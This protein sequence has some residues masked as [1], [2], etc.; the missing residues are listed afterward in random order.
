MF[1]EGF[2]LPEMK[3]AALHDIRKSLAVTL[4]LAGRFTRTGQ[5]LGDA[6]FIANIADIKVDDKIQKLY[7]ET[8]DWNDLLKDASEQTIQEKIDLQELVSGF[9]NSLT[10]ITIKNLTPAMSTVIYKTTCENWKPENYKKGIH[11]SDSF[12]RIEH[13][14]NFQE[15]TLVLVTGKKILVDWAQSKDIFNWDWGLYILF[16]D[17]TQNLLFIHSS[18]KVIY[19]EKLAKAVAGEVELVKGGPVFR[20]FAGINLLKLQN[21]GLIEHLGRLIR[22]TMRAG[23]DVELGLTQAQKQKSSKSNIFG[24]GYESGNKTSIGCSYKG[25]IWSRR[26]TNLNTLRK[27]CSTIGNKIKDDLIDPDEVLKG[28]LVQ[29]IISQRP[30]KI[31]IGIEWP[32]AIFKESETTFS[33]VVD[34]EELHLFQTDIML[35]APSEKGDLKFEICSDTARVQCKLILS[36]ENYEFS[37]E[38]KTVTVKRNT[39]SQLLEEFFFHDPP[40]IWF[41]DRSS[42]EG[43]RYIDLSKEFDPYPKEKIQTWNWNGVDIKKES[44]GK[45]KTQFSTESFG[46]YK[47]K[48]MI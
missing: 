45:L 9:Q 15:Q 11:G 26:K 40:K 29:K 6:T 46:S 24:T 27:W 21:V 14:I 37:V 3:I 5:N 13:D 36:E 25:R 44:Q 38:N 42:L 39:K 22:Y 2:D 18:D 12:N 35:I 32:E 28:T 34:D 30:E 33:F 1:G 16:W 19:Y 17:K 4:Q 8:S 31:P 47:R 23:A 41:V 10:D 48:T 43:N 7:N 20:C